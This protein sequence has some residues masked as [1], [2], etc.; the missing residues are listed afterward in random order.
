MNTLG[1][2]GAAFRVSLGGQNGLKLG[3]IQVFLVQNRSLKDF[4]VF[5]CLLKLFSSIQR[6]F[7]YQDF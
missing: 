3:Q 4:K 6:T 5:D 7:W 2:L 1:L